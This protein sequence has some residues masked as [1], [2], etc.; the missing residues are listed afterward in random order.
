MAKHTDL[1]IIKTRAKLTD[2]FFEMLKEKTF[3]EITVFDLCNEAEIRRATFYKHYK[4]KS[5]FLSY[6]VS[7]LQ[8]EIFERINHIRKGNSFIDYYVLYVKEILVYL[9]SDPRPIRKLLETTEFSAIIGTVL[10]S[11][12]SSLVRDLTADVERGL[13]LPADIKRI[14]SFMN[15]GLGHMVVEWMTSPTIN[16]DELLAG[17]KAILTKLLG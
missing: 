11:T 7:F 5:D 4:D 3:D 17:V 15:G 2:T 12:Y 9:E 13:R 6:I 1:R 8:N 14:A 16:S 10:T